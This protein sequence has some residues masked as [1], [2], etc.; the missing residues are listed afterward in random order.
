[1][2]WR[3]HG[4]VASAAFAHG[5]LW[6]RNA[7]KVLK[8]NYTFSHTHLVQVLLKCNSIVDQTEL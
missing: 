6:L 7:L 4:N 5:R 3:F 2:E 1:M 8:T